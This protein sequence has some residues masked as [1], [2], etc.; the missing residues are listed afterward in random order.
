M[1]RRLGEATASLRTSVRR[2][3][4]VPVTNA[5]HWGPQPELTDGVVTLT[6]FEEEDVPTMVEWDGDP[7]MARWFDF[8]PLPPEREHSDHVRGV[9]AAWH[10][11]YQAGTRI[12][13]AVTDMLTGRLLGSVE[14]RPRED[15]GADVSYSTHPAHRRKGFATRALR[16][17]SSWALEH[18]FTHL[19]AE[20]DA[21]NL[22]SASVARGAG[23]VEIDRRRGEMTYEHG[24]SPGDRVVAERRPPQ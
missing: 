22:E 17:A 10:A 18:G 24:G 15:G 6:A 23:F 21:R 13:W 14:L 5:S 20:Y 16:L 7:E 9:I 11:E 3:P 2:P 12:P 19:V 4:R 1:C 8:P